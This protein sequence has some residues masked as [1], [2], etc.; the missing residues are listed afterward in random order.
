[1]KNKESESFIKRHTK[2][3]ALTAGVGGT[4]FFGNVAANEIPRAIEL[5]E[6]SHN[7]EIAYDS[8]LQ[9]EIY[10]SLYATYYSS[11]ATVV[12]VVVAAGA[13]GFSVLEKTTKTKE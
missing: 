10:D 6:K 3:I 7:P 12:S 8:H 1:M 11:L 9:D 13:V 5:N 4:L 2:S